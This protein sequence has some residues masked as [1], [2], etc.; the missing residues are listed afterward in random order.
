MSDDRPV[1]ALLHAWR[2]GDQDA[3]AQ[4]MGLVHEELHRLAQR[5]MRGE[6]Q[7]HTLQA[8]ALVNEAYLRLVDADVAW[9]DRAHFFAV[10]ATTMRRILV[11]HARSLGRQKRAGIKVSLEESAIVA[12]DSSAE[13]VAIDEALTRLAEQD[14]RAAQVVE[15]HYFGGLTYEE[16]AEAVGTS[17]ATVHRDLRFAKAWLYRELSN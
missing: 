8:T 13:L 2:S 12:A 5:Y 14:A 4:L 9:K 17:P 15:L 3:L 6:R 7:D 11:D 10:A 16:I 1:T